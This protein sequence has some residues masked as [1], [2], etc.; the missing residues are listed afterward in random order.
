MHGNY[1]D[2]EKMKKDIRRQTFSKPEKPSDADIKKLTDD[3]NIVSPEPESAES[4]TITDRR[5]ALA[6]DDSEAKQ[7]HKIR[8]QPIA[9]LLNSYFRSLPA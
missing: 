5:A 1:G 9:G 4:A 3:E 6:I 2:D 8:A 7:I